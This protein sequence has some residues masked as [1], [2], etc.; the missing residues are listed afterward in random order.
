M[1]GLTG[2]RYRIGRSLLNGITH[3]WR[4]QP[5]R[6]V[7]L[8]LVLGLVGSLI[9]TL[10]SSMIGLL[11]RDVRYTGLVDPLI[12]SLVALFFFI[13]YFLVT[14]TTTVV[15]WSGLFRTPASRFAAQLPVDDRSLYWGT[16]LDAVLIASW[17]TLVLAVPALVALRYEALAPGAYLWSCCAALV[18]FVLLCLATAGLCALLLARLIPWLR[19]GYRFLIVAGFALIGFLVVGALADLDSARAAHYDWLNRVLDRIG[20]VDHP[21]LPGKWMQEAVRGAL[22]RDWASWG[23][24][25]GLL[26]SSAGALAL[27]G[28]WFAHRRFRRELDALTCRAQGLAQRAILRP[29]RPLPCLPTDL[30]L[31][32]AKDLVSFRR[33]PAQLLQFGLF[34]GMLTFYVLMLP[35]IG[36][37]FMIEDWW[38]TAVSVLNLVAISMAMATFTGRFVFP[39]PSM[40]GKRLWVLSLAPW[41][42]RRILTGKFIFAVLVGVPISAVLVGLSS[43]F[44][45][46]TG[47]LIA[48]Q[49]LVAAAIGCGLVASALGIG[50]ALANLDE[51]DPARLVAGF[52]GTLNLLLSLL[53]CGLLIGASCI[54]LFIDNPWYGWGGGLLTV[55]TIA[56][57]WTWA[58]LQQGYRAFDRLT[59]GA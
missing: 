52:G 8:V 58:F 22:D 39:L 3:S 27:A 45:E 50:T 9:Y 56:T 5:G 41:S 23:W 20:F 37:A 34:F 10:V 18:A 43:L 59:Q 15:I 4:R 21:L 26:L 17:G 48:F 29:L 38:A 36:K 49:I 2:I 6:L 53:Y 13:L 32:L 51:D 54:P 35:R 57:L 14:G 47:G 55:L 30:G 44:L 19:R 11:Q 16:L 33:D 46:M 7:T 31:L 25:V 40:E 42:K 28:E 24:H 12:D 1:Q